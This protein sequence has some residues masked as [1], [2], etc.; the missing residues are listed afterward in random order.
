MA[1]E[2]REGIIQLARFGREQANRDV[3]AGFAQHLESRARDQRIG[4]G[5]RRNGARHTGF[6]QRAR[7]RTRA[8]VVAARLQRDVDSRAARGLA[9][10]RERNHF[11]MIALRVLMEATTDDAMV[12]HED[13][14]DCRIRRREADALPRERRA[15]PASSAGLHSRVVQSYCSGAEQRVGECG[16][17]EGQQ[18]VELLAH[19]DEAHG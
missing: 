19:A 10:F 11:S 2:M 16:A 17:V 15:Q 4:I 13:A 14:A 12:A 6:D 8:S 1:D 9:C 7:T 5:S 3:D 18:V